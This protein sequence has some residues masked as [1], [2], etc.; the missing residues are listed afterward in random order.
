MNHI[1]VH[2]DSTGQ[3]GRLLDQLSYVLGACSYRTLERMG[4]T[5]KSKGVSDRKYEQFFGNLHLTTPSMN[6]GSRISTSFP[7]SSSAFAK[8]NADNR[9]TTVAH[10]MASPIYLPAQ[11]LW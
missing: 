10:T 2:S 4:S 1:H 7:N 8:L 5:D 9:D 11:I 6:K 3:G